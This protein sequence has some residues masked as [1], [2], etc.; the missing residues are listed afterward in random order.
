MIIVNHRVNTVTA[1]Q[2][3][4]REY[5]VEIDIRPYNNRLILNH[6]PFKDGENLE[7]F[8]QNYNHKLLILNVKSEGIEKNVLDLVNN[9]NIQDYFFLDITFPFMIKYIKQGWSKMALRFSEYESIE[10]CLALKGKADWVFV[11]NFTKLPVENNS[12]SILKKYFKLCIVSPELL[13]RGA[14]I[15]STQKLVKDYR[16]DAVLADDLDAWRQ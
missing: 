15:P 10:T 3:T 4:P 1:L 12:F 6:E 14:E 7:T 9:Y 8:L 13:N 16:I 5:G 11:D 2:G